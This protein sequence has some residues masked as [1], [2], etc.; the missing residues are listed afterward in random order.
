MKFKVELEYEIGSTVGEGPIWDE[1]SQHLVW[2][3]VL[4][5]KVFFYSPT[6]RSQ[7]T[8]E[9]KSHVGAVAFDS[10]HNLVIAQRDGIS[11]LSRSTGEI[12]Y[13]RKIIESTE[14]RFN[15]GSVDR[16]GR[17]VVGSMG[18]QPTE[19]S[20]TLYS[21]SLSGELKTLIPK[22]GISNGVCWNSDSSA[23]YYIDSLTNSIQVFEYNLES[24][25]ISN[26]KVLMKFDMSEGTPDGMTIDTDGNLW[27]A[28]WGGAKVV[29][30]NPDGITVARIPFPV[31]N[32]TS[33]TF[34]GADMSTL[35][36]TTAR[37]TLSA[38]A[39]MNEPLAG[40]LFS[41]KTSSRGYLE[42]CMK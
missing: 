1:I 36:V 12:T 18:Y 6:Q 33:L 19:D 11:R 34:G 29:V 25:A 27:V 40:S 30:V 9:I 22:V 32:V 23:M 15:D 13:L 5:G 26:G 39:L 24:G 21:Y 20:G 42:N 4:E 35:F 38:Q 10:N 14:I 17:F 37:Y 31:T 7:K 8:I 16:A 41:I 28:M 2:I 3:D